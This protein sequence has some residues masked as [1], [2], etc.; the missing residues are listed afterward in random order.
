MSESTTTTDNSFEVPSKI[1]KKI[2]FYDLPDSE[3]LKLVQEQIDIVRNALKKLSYMRHWMRGQKTFIF[4]RTHL[5]D[6]V[7]ELSVG[8]FREVVHTLN[9]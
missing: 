7:Y 5:C 3:R 6:L 9:K 4:E 8:A 2:E 1:E